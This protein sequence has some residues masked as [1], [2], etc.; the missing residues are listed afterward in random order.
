MGRS[1]QKSVSH[2]DRKLEALKRENLFGDEFERDLAE[3]L[4]A[5]D[6]IGS[7]RELQMRQLFLARRSSQMVPQGSA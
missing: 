7:A 1:Q 4:A 2:S 5:D 6:S 3:H